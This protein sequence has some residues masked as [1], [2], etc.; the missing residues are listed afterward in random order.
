VATLTVGADSALAAVA[1]GEGHENT[2]ISILALLGAQAGLQARLAGMLEAAEGGED[3]AAAYAGL[4]ARV[5]ALVSGQL[6]ADGSE[7]GSATADVLISLLLGVGCPCGHAAEAAPS[8]KAT[9]AGP[10]ATKTGRPVLE[11]PSTATPHR[12]PPKAA[13]WW[14]SMWRG[15]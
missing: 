1:E 9:R 2:D 7:G 6:G 10:T 3:T 15:R 8:W 5:E 4:R 14:C 11:M 12:P 13:V